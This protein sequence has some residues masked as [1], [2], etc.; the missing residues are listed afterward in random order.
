MVIERV[1]IRQY[2]LVVIG[3]QLE[4]TTETEWSD[5]L[6]VQLLVQES[7]YSSTRSLDSPCCW[8]SVLGIAL[9]PIS[10]I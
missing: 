5:E 9:D 8:A 3:H 10:F 7:S 4:E 2:S 1:L 6:P